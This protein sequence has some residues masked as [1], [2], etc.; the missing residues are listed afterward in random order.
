MNVKRDYQIVLAAMREVFTG[1]NKTHINISNLAWLSGI[2][3]ED[4]SWM[5]KEKKHFKWYYTGKLNKK[6]KKIWHVVLSN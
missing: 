1:S 5:V 4:V 6:G 3:Y 2:T